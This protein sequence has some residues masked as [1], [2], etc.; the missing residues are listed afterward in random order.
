MNVLFVCSGNVSSFDVVPFIREQGEAIRSLGCNVDYFTVK[1]KG[2]SGYLKAGLSLFRKLS[3]NRYDIIH[4]HF[5]LSGYT[6]LIGSAFRIP[7]VL[8]LM[9]SDAYGQYVGD[10]KVIPTSRYT[11][12]MTWLIQPFMKAIISKS[13]NIDK[14]VY[15]RRKSFVIP[16]GIDRNKFF[17]DRSYKTELGLSATK[18]TILFLGSRKN[19]RK[20]LDLVTKALPYMKTTDVQLVNPYPVPHDAIP[21]YLNSVDVLAVP[22]FMEGSANVIK[23]AMACNC[24]VV[25]TDVGDARWVFGDTEGYYLSSFDPKEYAGRLD[26]A[27]AFSESRG[28]TKGEDRI[29]ELRLD[30]G[31]VAQRVVDVYQKVLHRSL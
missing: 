28:R 18:K 3:T 1:G 12:L 11:T 2:I 29:E 8:S 4:A 7:V 5:T 31:S 15:A 17:S 6:A 20:N 26:D 27:L 22:S 19:I 16:N 23:E 13:G 9:G 24:P 30:A 21:K 14:Y 25:A 10:R